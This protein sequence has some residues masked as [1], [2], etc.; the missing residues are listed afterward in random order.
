MTDHPSDEAQAIAALKRGE[1]AGL[2]LLVRR[3]QLRAI[4]AAY[5]VLRDRAQADDIVQTAFLRAYDRIEQ[6][7]ASRSFGPWFLRSVLNDAI[8]AASRQSRLVSL[9]ASAAAGDDDQAV[10]ADLLADPAP[11]PEALAESAELQAAVWRALGQLA[12][13]QRGA[14]VLRYY[15]NLSE[16]EMSVHSGSPPGT[17]KWRLHSARER[18]RTL[19][20]AA[21][22]AGPARNK[23][24]ANDE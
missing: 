12:P 21:A 6:F 10:L 7:D 22:P 16:S 20:W 9:D 19:L 17:V 13:A 15:L 23:Q 18:L 14:I 3:Y 4:R 1:I 2:E 5:L 8:K 11:G 24:E